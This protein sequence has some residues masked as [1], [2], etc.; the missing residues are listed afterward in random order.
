MDRL[1]VRELVYF[2]AVAE[3][4]H[5]SRA[6]DQLGIAQPPLSR[7]ISRLERR[8]GVKLLDRTSRSVSLTTAGQVFLRESRTALAAMDSVVKRTQK[9]ARPDKL[10]IAVRSGAGAG[11]LPAAIEAYSE[12]TD[13]VPVEVLF[14]PDQGE[15]LRDGRADL[16]L[17][18]SVDDV[19]GF[20]LTRLI[21]ESPVALLPAAHPLATSSG[22]TLADLSADTRYRATCPPLPLDEI[23]DRVA[24]GELIV[25]IGESV[26][27]RLGASARTVPVLD[28]PD[29]HLVLA[30]PRAVPMAARD[31]FVRTAAAVV[32]A[33]PSAVVLR[34][35]RI[36]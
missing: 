7:T 32:L 5:F 11:V 18:C 33:T 2:L 21:D 19:T 29:S 27:D 35:Q 14:T 4:L 15:A 3:N 6:A 26:A 1:E 30:S 25:V 8:I 36:H 10:V 34:H 22:V 13:P 24:L 17:M 9:A 16:A 31:A 23:V 28:L 12:T 20:D